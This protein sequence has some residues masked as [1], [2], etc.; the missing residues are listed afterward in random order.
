MGGPALKRAGRACSLVY[1]MSAK[2][3]HEEEYVLVKKSVLEEIIRTVEEIRAI[4]KEI[5]DE[6]AGKSK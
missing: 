6:G 3:E 1:Y 5:R 4:I 2:P